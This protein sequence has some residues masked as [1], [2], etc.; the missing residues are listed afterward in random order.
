ML[1]RAA[2]DAALDVPEVAEVRSSWPGRVTHDR[3]DLVEGVVC[4]AQS[5]G[6]YE[7]TLY[8]TVHPVPLRALAGR[9]RSQVIESAEYAGLAEELGRVDIVIEDLASD[10]REGVG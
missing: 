4:V 10:S 6:R 1:A 9:V 8:L 3:D 7:V 5:D 2:Y